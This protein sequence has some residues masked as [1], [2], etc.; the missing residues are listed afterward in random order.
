MQGIED[1]GSQHTCHAQA[2]EARQAGTHT[3]THWQWLCREGC[4]EM[5]LDPL[6]VPPAAAGAPARPLPV[7]LPLHVPTAAASV[8]VADVQLVIRILPVRRQSPELRCNLHKLLVVREGVIGQGEAGGGLV[9]AAFEARG[10]GV[11]GVSGYT[12]QPL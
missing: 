8:A 2:H 9:G 7:P 12:L 5:V 1:R 10:D 3:H 11:V 4:D 6:G